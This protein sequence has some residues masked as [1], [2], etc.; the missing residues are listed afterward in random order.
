M[1]VTIKRHIEIEV[2]VSGDYSPGDPGK[3]SGP[4][5]CPPEPEAIENVSVVFGY[6]E[7]A[8]MLDG[9][10]RGG[11]ECDLMDAARATLEQHREDYPGRY[12]REEGE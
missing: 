1:H 9:T 4:M 11:L 10:V 8:H 12:G 7:L 2:T 5:A 6:H 3:L